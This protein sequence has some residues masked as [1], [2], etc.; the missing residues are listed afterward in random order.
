MFVHESRLAIRQKLCAKYQLS[1]EQ[2]GTV[3][4]RNPLSV[5]SQLDF[6]KSRGGIMLILFWIFILVL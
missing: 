1:L 4:S 5:P 3:V 6:I 2:E